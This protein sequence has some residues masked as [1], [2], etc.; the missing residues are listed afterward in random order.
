MT[1]LDLRAARH[2][3]ALDIDAGRDLPESAELPRTRPDAPAGRRS[4]TIAI[5][6]AAR[7]DR[8][9]Q[10]TA[11][12]LGQRRLQHGEAV[13][14]KFGTH[15]V[16]RLDCELAQRIEIGGGGWARARASAGHCA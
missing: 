3:D 14:R 2:V 12:D 7:L 13:G 8:L 10:L 16:V 1:R 4:F 15:D 6:S 5:S 11:A 9:E